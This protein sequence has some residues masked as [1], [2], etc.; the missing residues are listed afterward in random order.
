MNYRSLQPSDVS[1]AFA[2]RTATHENR[3]LREALSAAGITE[4]S[5]LANLS[6]HHRGWVCVEN[7]TVIG[8]SIADGDSG[9]LWTIAVRPE[10]EGRGIGAHL[11]ALAESWLGKLGWAE[12]WLWTSSQR[13]TRAFQLYQK[14]GW[15]VSED[16]GDQLIM[17][18]QLRGDS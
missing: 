13:Q 10:C 12:T 9:E 1:A 5:V 2:I 7:G 6:T 16:N 4:E 11:L 8:F 15:T 14:R 3:F 18:K 17:K